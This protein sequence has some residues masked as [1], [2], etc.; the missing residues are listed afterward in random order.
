MYNCMINQ[1]CARLSRNQR[2][3]CN[4]AAFAYWAGVSSPIGCG[5]YSRTQAKTCTCQRTWGLPDNIITTHN[6]HHIAIGT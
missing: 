6:Q 2:E 3:T 5:V 4:A 1:V